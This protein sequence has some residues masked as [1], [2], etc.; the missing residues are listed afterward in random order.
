MKRL[1][2]FRQYD[3]N[4]YRITDYGVSCLIMGGLLIASVTGIIIAYIT[5]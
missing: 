5:H 4:D 2:M 3:D 1:K